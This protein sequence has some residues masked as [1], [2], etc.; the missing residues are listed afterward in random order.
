MADADSTSVAPSYFH[1]AVPAEADRIAWPHV[2]R[3]GDTAR[4]N[5]CATLNG[6]GID[7]GFSVS[8]KIL[9]FQSLTECRIIQ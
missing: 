3:N 9:Y 1:A 6:P 8:K 4:K 7:Q 5:A 2:P